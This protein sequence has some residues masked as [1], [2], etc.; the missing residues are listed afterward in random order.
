V[1]DILP[2]AA[3]PSWV[4]AAVMAVRPYGRVVLMGGVGMQGGGGLEL[5]YAWIMRNCV[6][7]IG[8]WL[9]PREAVS[10][11]AG[12]IRA[13]LIRLD[14]YAVASFDLDHVNAAVAHAADHAGPF[15]MTVL[16]P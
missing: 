4:R 11:M 12:L 5:P 9:C 13:G 6:T 1:L 10:P 16:K 7:I 3:S 2:P 15:E 8:Q 14:H